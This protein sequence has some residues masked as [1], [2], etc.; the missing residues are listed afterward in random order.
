M[1]FGL[2]LAVLG[3]VLAS[4]MSPCFAQTQQQQQQSY[5]YGG[6][7]NNGM[8]LYNSAQNY[9]SDTTAGSIYN[10]GQ[11]LQLLPMQQMVAG[12]DA[13]SYAYGGSQKNQPYGFN[14]NGM[15]DPTAMGGLSPEQ[16]RMIRDQ[17]DARAAAYQ[18]QYLE[19]LQRNPQ[20]G[21]YTPGQEMAG[22]QY[23]G[24][25]FSQLYAQNGQPK[26]PVK[27][28]VLYNQLNNPLV[29]PPRLFNPDK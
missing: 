26:P 5:V 12:K 27:R 21:P 1:R 3:F 10:T 8:P 15:L 14:N 25:Q 11:N 7:N 22:S 23:Q 2:P 24:S 17:R 18:Q 13:P 19:S 28:K 4:G 16:A 29:D 20:V 9:R 6:A